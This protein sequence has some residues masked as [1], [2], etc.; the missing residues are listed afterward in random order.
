MSEFVVN[1]FDLQKCKYW[2]LL[3]GIVVSNTTNDYS[4]VHA[5]FALYPYKYPIAAFT[6]AQNI[7][8]VFNSLVHKVSRD[9]KWLIETLDNVRM[10]GLHSIL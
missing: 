4:T 6:E 3:N 1:S 5:P 8:P 7:A 9:A 10:S 2:A